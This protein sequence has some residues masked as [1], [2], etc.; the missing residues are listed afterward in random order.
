MAGGKV[1]VTATDWTLSVCL[2]TMAE[3]KVL[4]TATD[5]DT[6]QAVVVL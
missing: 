5:W 2:L 3:G 1:L 6:E 4:V